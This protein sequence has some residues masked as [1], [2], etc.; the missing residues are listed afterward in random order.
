LLQPHKDKNND[1]PIRLYGIIPLEVAD[2]TTYLKPKIIADDEWKPDSKQTVT[3]SEE[4]GKT[5]NYT[6]AIVDEGLLGLTA[7]KTPDLHRHFY[8]KEALGIKTWDLFDEVIG[9]YGGKLER[10]LALGGGDDAESDNEDSKKRRFPPV[11]Q[12]L[13]PFKLEAGKTAKHEIKIPTYLGAVRVMLVAGEKGAYGK[14]QK[15]VF[16]RQA[17]MMQASLPRVLGPDEEVS[18]PVTLFALDESIK[19]VNINIETDDLI[20]VVDDTKKQISFSKTGEKLAFIKLKT[21]GREG[22]THLHFTATAGVNG[23]HSSE[24][25]IY[26][27]IRRANQETTRTTSKI[28]EPGTSWSDQAKAFGITGT[29]N[30]TLELS[31]VPSLNLE[32][33]L[34]Y[35]IR[36][37]HGCLEQTTSSAFPQLYLGNVMDLDKKKQQKAEHHIQKAIERLQRF[38]R[39]SGDFSYWPSG[40]HQ[41]DWASIYAGHF[42]IEAQK[43]G[44]LIPNDLLSKWLSAQVDKAQQYTAGSEKYSHTQAYRLYVLALA[45]KPQLGAMN[46]LR[47]SSK[48]NKKAR[49]LLASAY[50]SASQ[51]DAAKAVIQ[52]MVPSVKTV[53]TVDNTFS[54]T[55]GDL[56]L[57]L[58]SLITLGK[59]QDANQ[60]LEK[61]ADEMSGDD[62]QSTQGIAWAL[63]GVSRYLGGDTSHFSAT[64]T[65]EGA[66]SEINS[67]KP[68]SSIQLTNTNAEFNLKNTNSVKLFA[69]LVNRGVPKAGSEQSI[70][71][72]LALKTSFEIRDD[73]NPKKWYPLEGKPAIQ[74]GDVR[75]TANI[76]NT[77]KRDLE[78]IALTI[79]VAAGMEIHPADAQASSS[80]FDYRDIRDD[81]IHYYFPLKKGETKEFK[82]LATAAY[83]GRYYLPAINVE[84][85]YD[86]NVRARQ[87]GTWI[88]I[89]KTEEEFKALMDKKPV[90]AADAKAEDDISSIKVEKAYLYNDANE[91]T[92]TKMY[93]ISGDKVKILKTQKASDNSRWLFIHFEGKT[94]LE[95][96]IRAEVTE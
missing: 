32:S 19:N 85:M 4:T 40:S 60:L 31:S 17:L 35:L 56:G 13:G 14:A 72:G 87:K 57:Q 62:F 8:S 67:D 90:P 20:S 38:Q 86:G 42:L 33:R 58:E 27:D 65:Q 45:S 12:F 2:P 66:D 26:L 50:Q 84:A 95:K 54:S 34:N 93:L 18:V 63:M 78:N 61:I 1:R 73:E 68:I 91:T 15:S 6:L 64:L 11:V 80:K 41:N 39:G 47:E 29:N 48:L 75:F 37:P 36:Y 28:I 55:L 71:K 77:S 76:S 59:K 74:G 51:P 24:A 3:V 23:E 83:K 82:L 70:Q 53:N 43:K 5:M 10:M 94:V 16:V 21:A 25:D 81:R 52:G 88:N 49:W 79:P 9:A 89:V 22:K 92:R 30:A 7:F 96:W 44:Y 46:R 69:T